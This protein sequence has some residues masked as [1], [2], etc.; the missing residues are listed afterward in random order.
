[1][2]SV[3]PIFSMIYTLF[4]TEQKGCRLCSFDCEDKGAYNDVCN[5]SPSMK[6]GRKMRPYPRFGARDGTCSARL[7]PLPLRTTQDYIFPRTASVAFAI[8]PGRGNSSYGLLP[9]P[10]VQVPTK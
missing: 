3:C 6:K 2:F 4:Q 7:S 1:M 9:F 5:R 8:T 10:P